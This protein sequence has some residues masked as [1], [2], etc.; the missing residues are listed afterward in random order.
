M[1]ELLAK[2]DDCAELSAELAR[3]LV[4]RPPIAIGDEAAI[5]AGFDA[6]LDELRDAARRRQGRDRAHPDR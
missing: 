1:R 6:E 3:A 2:W 5:R 4:E